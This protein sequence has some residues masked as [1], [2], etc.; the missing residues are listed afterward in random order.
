V[1]KFAQGS[2]KF[3]LQNVHFWILPLC[4]QLTV[5]EQN[6]EVMMEMD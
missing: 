1:I 6:V 2:I 4:F 5:D 3:C